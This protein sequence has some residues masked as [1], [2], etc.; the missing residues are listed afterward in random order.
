MAL[1]PCFPCKKS[2]TA[3]PFRA[4]VFVVS[5]SWG[6]APEIHI[7]P[8]WGESHGRHIASGSGELRHLKLLAGS[9]IDDVWKY[10]NEQVSARF[11]DAYDGLLKK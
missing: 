6:V 5:I 7:W 1:V 2:F 4:L 3:L 11:L 10:V 9:L 8:R